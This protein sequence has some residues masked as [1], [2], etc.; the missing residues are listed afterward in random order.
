M[1]RTLLYFYLKGV[2]EFPWDTRERFWILFMNKKKYSYE[3]DSYI[4][5]INLE[6]VLLRLRFGHITFSK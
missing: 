4:M 1:S 6:F 5:K 3:Y 2:T